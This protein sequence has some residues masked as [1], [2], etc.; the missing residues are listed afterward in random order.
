MNPFI[1]CESDV[2]T[3]ELEGLSAGNHALSLVLVEEAAGL[4][5]EVADAHLLH[6]RLCRAG[7]VH[8]HAEGEAWPLR[9]AATAFVPAGTV[10][11]WRIG[12]SCRRL[13]LRL[14]AQPLLDL[15]R[16][17][18]RDPVAARMREPAHDPAIEHYAALIQNEAQR[19]GRIDA[20]FLDPI[21]RLL[22]MHVLRAYLGEARVSAPASGLDAE[23]RERIDRYIRRTLPNPIVIEELAAACDLSQYQLTRLLKRAL[24]VSPQQYVQAR[25]I[26]LAR[27]LLRESELSL[28]D[29][30]LELGFSSQ[31][32]FTTVF[33]ALTG[34]TPRTFRERHDL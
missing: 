6:F 23:Q 22:G 14:E 33:R 5:S 26:D 29:I 7:D 15:A 18:G 30:A 1:R 13:S 8:L 19:L 9:P 11:S 32:H 24:G 21:A 17:I 20:A 2:S 27:K 31:S 28:T 3:A 25:R 16:A 10:V 34:H 4:R 12:V